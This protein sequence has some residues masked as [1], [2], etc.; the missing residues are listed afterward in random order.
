[1][2][3]SK[4]LGRNRVALYEPAMHD[5]VAQRAALLRDLVT[6]LDTGQFQL[7][8][9]PQYDP[10]GEVVGAEMLLRWDH[11]TQGT[12]MP[13]AFIDLVEESGVMGKVGEWAL[14][15]ACA[16]HARLSALGVAHPI[17]VNVSATQ[18]R[19]ADF[20][21]RVV[22]I[23][24]ETGTPPDQIILE[25]TESVL[26]DDLD[27]T[28][29]RMTALAQLG[30]RFSIDDFGTG[31]SGL[32]YLRKL[33]L[34]ELKIDSSFVHDLPCNDAGTL[35]RLIIA[36][37]GLLELRVVAEGV[38]DAEQADFLIGV[39]CDILQGYL[40]RH[41]M[42]IEAW[43]HERSA[44]AGANPDTDANATAPCRATS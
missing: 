23:L 42:P 13:D 18:L 19:Q 29:R 26:I 17:S 43:V 15:Q 21:E 35:I 34:Y 9:Q 28:A 41:P 5:Q 16:L 31:Y 2:Y 6:V 36:T 12:I 25:L 1:M 8:V 11:P 33:P 20:H 39:G 22:A 27:D 32:S 7:L 24:A 37:A 14:Q 44:S 10:Q 4:E 3:R 40:Y 30:L 38:E